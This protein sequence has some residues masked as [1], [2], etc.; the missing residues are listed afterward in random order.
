M[1]FLIA[2]VSL[3][4]VYELARTVFLYKRIHQ[5]IRRH[6]RKWKR[7]NKWTTS[8]VNPN[9]SLYRYAYSQLPVEQLK[10]VKLSLDSDK[11]TGV[12]FL[13]IDLFIKI[14]L[15]IATFFFGIWTA[16]SNIYS[17]SEIHHGEITIWNIIPFIRQLSVE[18]TDTQ[19]ISLL[20]V[21]VFIFL[22]TLTHMVYK[23]VRNDVITKL[24]TLMDQIIAENEPVRNV[25][26]SGTQLLEEDDFRSA[27]FF[28][29]P[30]G[31]YNENKPVSRGI[32]RKT[33]YV[34]VTINKQSFEKTGFVFKVM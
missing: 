2:I 24:V 19:L 28:Q 17:S 18:A 4:I 31:V 29:L 6:V 34:S 12:L 15:P 8:I 21:L 11:S 25:F 5:P 10:H 13:A 27:A 20:T 33:S 7:F 32:I 14:L 26:L 22:I 1:E 23:K 3:L 9:L 16:L 30:I